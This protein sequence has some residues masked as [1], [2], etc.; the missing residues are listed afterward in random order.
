MQGICTGKVNFGNNVC[1]G[2][3][4]G[5][6]NKLGYGQ[7]TLFSK[8]YGVHRV[9]WF[10]CKGYWPECVDHIDRNPWNN[11]I[12]NLREGSKAQ[13][14]TNT[15]KRKG[16][17]CRFKGVS[18]HKKSNKWR[19]QIQHCG[20]VKHIGTFVSDVEAAKAYDKFAEILFGD[21]ASLNFPKQGIVL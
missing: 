19:S 17:T 7:V 3:E 21:F 20:T 15:S 18:F 4:A 6:F 8:P 10:L 2:D 14:N 5:A 11:D 12:E 13:N 9:V 1:K 16:T